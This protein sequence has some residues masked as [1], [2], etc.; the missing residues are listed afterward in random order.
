MP[1]KKTVTP[2]TPT[3][4]TGETGLRQSGGLIREEFHAKLQGSAA[5]KMYREMAD[6]HPIIGAA[7]KSIETLMLQVKFRIDGGDARARKFIKECFEDKNAPTIE[8]TLQEALTVL[9]YG[10]CSLEK[11]YKVRKGGEGS[12]Y[13]DGKI[14]WAEFAPRAQESLSRWELDVV[15]GKPLGW[16]QWRMNRGG[17][18][19][20]PMENLIHF[21]LRGYAGNPEG[22]SWLRNAYVPYNYQKQIKIV[23]AIGIERRLDGLPVM[24]VPPEVMHPN[25][26]S[27]LAAIR[28]DMETMVQRIRMDQYAGLVLPSE[29]DTQGKPTGYK[30][31]L[32]STS[33]AFGN[34][35]DVAIGRYNQEI[36]LSLLAQFLLLGTISVGSFAL[37]SNKTELF[38]QSLSALLK[39]LLGPLNDEVK[40]LCEVNGFKKAPKIKHS[41]ISKQSLGEVANY[42]TQLFGSASMLDPV[43]QAYLRDVAD[44]PE[45]PPLQHVLPQ[46]PNQGPQSAAANGARAAESERDNA[47]A[48]GAALNPEAEDEDDSEELDSN[49]Q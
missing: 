9:V 3:T 33:S 7:I 25:A 4:P 35:A 18:T 13:N 30:F 29:L 43:T 41:P 10:W 26:S 15:N 46:L 5:A 40:L 24:E 28:S 14:A 27:A 21:K 23:E 49:E 44:L 38:A 16:Y 12:E 42:V 17:E 45:G 11:I 48:V 37:S 32:L 8:G 39:G 31:R 6:N 47:M 20:L 22:K 19:F 36:A 34:Q 2:P 1:R